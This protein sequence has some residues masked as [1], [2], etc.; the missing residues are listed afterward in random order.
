VQ[1]VNRFCF[2]FGAG[3]RD[4]ADRSMKAPLAVYSPQKEVAELFLLNFDL[5]VEERKKFDL[6]SK[7]RGKSGVRSVGTN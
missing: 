1:T 4:G 2:D 3:L 5:A 7:K 6:S